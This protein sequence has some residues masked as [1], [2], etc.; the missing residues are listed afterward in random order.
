MNHVTLPHHS[1]D[2]EGGGERLVEALGAASLFP[3]PRAGTWVWAS[4]RALTRQ[5]RHCS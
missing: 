4:A 5:S 3:H 2:Q 1:R